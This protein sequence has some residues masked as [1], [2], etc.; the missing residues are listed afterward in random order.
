MTVAYSFGLSEI[1]PPVGLNLFVLKSIVT[2]IPMGEIIRAVNPFIV[3]DLIFL[4]LVMVFPIIILGKLRLVN[5]V[6]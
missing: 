1:T 4:A 5:L 3:I 2:D 6:L